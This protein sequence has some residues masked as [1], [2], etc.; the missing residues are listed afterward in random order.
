[1]KQ[2]KP[3]DIIRVRAVGSPFEVANNASRIPQTLNYVDCY[4]VKEEQFGEKEPVY[5]VS[6]REAYTQFS[7]YDFSTIVCAS[8]ANNSSLVG[9]GM[10]TN[11]SGYTI[12]QIGQVLVVNEDASGTQLYVTVLLTN[13]SLSTAYANVAVSL[14]VNITG[15]TGLVASPVPTYLMFNVGQIG[16]AS[17][18]TFTVGGATPVTYNDPFYL[19]NVAP[20]P[21]TLT[22]AANTTN[23]NIFNQAVIANALTS[24]NPVAVTL[25]INAGVTVGLSS[26]Y[27][28]RYYPAM[29]TGTG[30]A[31]GS[32]I[33]IVNQGTIMGGGGVGVFA[34]AGGTSYS[35][36]G[37]QALQM[38][39]P[40]TLVNT[41]TIAGGGGGGG[42]AWVAG[43]GSGGGGMGS[44]DCLAGGITAAAGS[45][46][47]SGHGGLGNPASVTG[48]ISVTTGVG[49]NGNPSTSTY[50][51]YGSGASGGGLGY[52]G[53]QGGTSYGGGAGI[54][55]GP[56]G[57][58]ISRSGNAL[59]G[60]VDGTYHGTVGS[61]IIHGQVG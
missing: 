32:T 27:T 11:L 42:A 44:G 17:L 20:T 16:S 47:Q 14:N 48:G 41:G 54:Y 37:G 29:T 59:T 28:A 6:I 33:K 31:S 53:G 52:S 58:A 51:Y 21:V 2:G 12:Q 39:W 38:K 49:N 5:S 34:G 36:M 1:M 4:P 10:P 8:V 7:S 30:W 60:V 15:G 23:Y 55:G 3:H 19:C 35:A 57:M 9:G 56:P 46:S 22:I 18:G 26:G 13:T 43:N 24:T 61:G 45:S 25:T 40:V 50:G